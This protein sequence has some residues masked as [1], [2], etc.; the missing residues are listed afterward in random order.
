MAH[1]GKIGCSSVESLLGIGMH[2]GG[3]TSTALASAQG[4]QQHH[5]GQGR[6][7]LVL[8]PGQL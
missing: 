8:H 2:T 3:L 1:A 7:V 5:A 4:A 6:E